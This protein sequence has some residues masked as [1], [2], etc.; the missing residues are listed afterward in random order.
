[1]AISVPRRIGL[2]GGTFD[3]IHLGHL[4]AA[5][6]V[7]EALGLEK[8]FFVLA[9][10]PPHKE[11]PAVDVRDRWEMLVRSIASNPRFEA[12]DVEIRRGGTSYSVETVRY[13]RKHLKGG[14]LFFILG[15]DAFS[16]L[17][18]WREYRTLL[19][20]AHFVVVSREGFEPEKAPLVKEEGYRR[21]GEGRYVHPSG[22]S[23][24]FLP[25]T[26]IGI[27]STFIRKAIREGKSIRYLL[28]PEAERYI[29]EKGLYR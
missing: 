13:Y 18:T 9:A 24:H 16:E 20:L 2:F 23:L 17:E 21:E 26:P 1:M 25:I 11:G 15:A 27:S 4:R 7:A 14:E 29:E 10:H 8:V 6:E 28:P 5:E 22:T 19:T 12:S 3:P